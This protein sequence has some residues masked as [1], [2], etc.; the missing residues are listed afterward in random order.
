MERAYSASTYFFYEG[1]AVSLNTSVRAPG[2]ESTETVDYRTVSL[3]IIINSKYC[4][5]P[6][7]IV[8]VRTTPTS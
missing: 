5:L 2:H 6:T 8:P 1:L 3:I 7:L 4:S